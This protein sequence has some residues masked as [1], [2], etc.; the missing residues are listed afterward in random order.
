MSRYHTVRHHTNKPM[1]NHGS[2]RAKSRRGGNVVNKVNT[3]STLTRN[4]SRPKY[5]TTKTRQSK[6]ETRQSNPEPRMKDSQRLHKQHPTSQTC[7]Y[8]AHNEPSSTCRNGNCQRQNNQSI[9][10]STRSSIVS[11]HSVN[12]GQSLPHLEFNET[13]ILKTQFEI[14]HT[15]IPSKNLSLY[16]YSVSMSDSARQKSLKDALYNVSYK[17]VESRLNDLIYKYKSN[18]NIAN[19][20]RN[21]LRWIKVVADKS[22]RIQQTQEQRTRSKHHIEHRRMQSRRHTRHRR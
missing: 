14:N 10:L 21:D 6:P 8:G 3:P 16:N 20:L 5:Q 12:D 9:K 7:R 13:P 22:D 11:T 18:P 15:Q 19:M 2:L 4:Q 17:V 1:V